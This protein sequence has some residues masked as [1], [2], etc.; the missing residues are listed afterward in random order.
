MV[1]TEHYSRVLPAQNRIPLLGVS[2][3]TLALSSSLMAAGLHPDS[4]LSGLNHLTSF[5]LQS[6]TSFA[7]HLPLQALLFTGF[8]STDIVLLIEIMALKVKHSAFQ[9]V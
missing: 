5:N 2:M 8:I 9:V 3:I 4:V 7:N 1:R 6:L